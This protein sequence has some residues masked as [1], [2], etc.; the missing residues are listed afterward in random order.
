MMKR[1]DENPVTGKSLNDLAKYDLKVAN[2][3]N[4]DNEDD[5]EDVSKQLAEKK[6]H[7]S[8][9]IPQNSPNSYVE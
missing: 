5:D 2:T 7:R 8:N 1:S 3:E 4:V 6:L 9:S